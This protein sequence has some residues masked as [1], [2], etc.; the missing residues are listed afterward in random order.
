MALNKLNFNYCH[1]LNASATKWISGSGTAIGGVVIDSGKFDW[2]GS[3]KF[4]SFTEP[5]AGFHGLK[6]AEQ[7]GESVFAVKVR[8]DG[9]SLL[10]LLSWDDTYRFNVQHSSFKR[11][12]KLSLP[13]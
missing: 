4:P 13:L 12:R 8:L 6:F 1:S 10:R 9:E 2:I 3:G 5:H 7:F 11:F